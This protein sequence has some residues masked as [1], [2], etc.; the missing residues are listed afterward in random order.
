MEYSYMSLPGWIIGDRYCILMLG[1]S[2]NKFEHGCD[3][4]YSVFHS[5]FYNFRGM[6]YV[7]SS[8]PEVKHSSD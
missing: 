8:T 7:Y 1:T 5:F 2:G 4:Q 6:K 3:M